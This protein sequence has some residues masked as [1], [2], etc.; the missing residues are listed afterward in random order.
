MNYIYLYIH[1]HD[2]VKQHII[3]WRK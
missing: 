1:R 2:L 3:N